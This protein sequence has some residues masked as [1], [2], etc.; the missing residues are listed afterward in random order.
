MGFYS[1]NYNTFCP[2]VNVNEKGRITLKNTSL[3]QL[4]S[5][6]NKRQQKRACRRNNTGGRSGK[7]IIQG[8]IYMIC[9][10]SNINVYRQ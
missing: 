6:F 8:G 4:V 10:V 1:Y 7:E 2:N 9:S 5:D 3:L